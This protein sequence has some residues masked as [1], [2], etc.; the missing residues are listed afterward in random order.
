M[1]KMGKQGYRKGVTFEENVY[2][3]EFWELEKGKL[4]TAKRNGRS[5]VLPQFHFYS[6][7]KKKNENNTFSYVCH[8][9]G[10]MFDNR[11]S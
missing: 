1:T 10:R 8:H 3:I 7:F 6:S 4:W 9:I 11:Q 2:L 5:K